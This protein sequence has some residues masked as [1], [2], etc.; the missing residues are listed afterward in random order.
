M[1]VAIGI[2]ALIAAIIYPG[3]GRFIDARDHVAERN[4]ALKQ[5]QMTMTMLEQDLRYASPRAVRDGFGDSEGAL[6]ST[7]LADLGPGELMR[8]TVFQPNARLNPVQR[9]R[10][11]AWRLNDGVLSR[12]SWKVLDRD[13]DSEELKRD[14]LRQ[15]ADLSFQF[16]RHGPDNAIETQSEWNDGDALPSGVEILLTLDNGRQYRRVFDL[17]HGS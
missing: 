3:F 1:I 7:T 14:F 10:R 2:F 16:L 9:L 4:E 6:V 17:A 5:L 13:Q 12:I 15:V 11:V 8:L